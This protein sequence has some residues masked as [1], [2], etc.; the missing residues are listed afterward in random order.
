MCKYYFTVVPG[1]GGV[2]FNYFN[3]F[4]FNSSVVKSSAFKWGSSEKVNLRGYEIINGAGEKKKF[5]N[6]NL[7][8]FS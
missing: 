4:Y 8:F 7:F 5:C 1:Q 3:Y 6:T 2:S